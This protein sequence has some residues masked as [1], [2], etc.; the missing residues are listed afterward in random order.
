V[1]LRPYITHPE[2]IIREAII[3][4]SPAALLREMQAVETDPG[5]RALISQKL[6]Q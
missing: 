6:A 2:R 1:A 4:L 3:K 5:L